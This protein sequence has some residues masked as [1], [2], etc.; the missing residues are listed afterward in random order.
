MT[1]K[2]KQKPKAKAAKGKKGPSR[3]LFVGQYLIDRNGTQ[4]AIRCGY[5]PRSA[6]VTA[7]RMLK[8]AKIKAEIAEAEAAQ[9]ERTQI[10]ADDVLREMAKVG[11]ASMRSFIKIDQDG[12]PV[13]DLRNTPDDHLDALSEI[14]TETVLEGGDNPQH[15]RKTKIKLHDKLRALHD[16]AVATNVFEKSG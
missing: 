12:Q 10:R 13:I 15:I 9:A 8:D 4:A 3:H 6:A 5:S 16:L 2:P 11:F 14:S 1:A 7:S